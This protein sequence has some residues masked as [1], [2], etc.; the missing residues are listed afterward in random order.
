MVYQIIDFLEVMEHNFFFNDNKND[1]SA[2]C[3]VLF[4]VT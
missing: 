4:L 3:L 2:M 1:F